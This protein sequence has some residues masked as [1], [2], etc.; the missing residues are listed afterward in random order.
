MIIINASFLCRNLTGIERFAFEICKRL[1]YLI[2]KDEIW[3]YV[4]HNAKKIPDYK[5]IKIIVSEKELTSFPVWDHFIFSKF[6]K[7]NQGIS[8]G[9]ANVT[10][11]FTPGYVFIHDIYAKLYPSDFVGFKDKLRRF[12]MCWMYR[13]AARRAKKIFTVSEFSKRQITETYRISSDRISVIPNGWEHF[14]SVNSDPS[15]FESFPQLKKGEYYFTLGSLQKRKNLKWILKYAMKN[16][17]EKFAISGKV[18]NG[19]QSDELSALKKLPNVILLGYVSDENVK[20]L[21]QNCKA[22]VFPSYYEGF[23]IPPLEALSVGAKIIVGNA[24]SLP[25]IYKGTALYI[26][27]YSTDC[28]IKELLKKKTDAPDMVLS[29]YTYDKAAKKLYNVL[30][31]VL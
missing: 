6:V 22:F 18:I 26:D 9:F 27:P 30:K 10:S 4:P 24:A 25:E 23:G 29:E 28:T 12:Y 20:S 16:P 19:M 14:E 3:M 8:L 15:I 2:Q 17:S 7:K 21:M 1:D 13:H 11:L 5:N 31:E